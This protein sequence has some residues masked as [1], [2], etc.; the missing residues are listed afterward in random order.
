M[1]K[2]F[3]AVI[4]CLIMLLQPMTVAHAAFDSDESQYNPSPGKYTLQETESDEYLQETEPRAVGNEIN[5]EVQIQLDFPVTEEGVNILKDAFTASLKSED[6]GE[7]TNVNTKTTS[8][9]TI[10]C[11]AENVQPGEYTLI[12]DAEYFFRNYQQKVFV[13][14][15]AKTTVVLSDSYASYRGDGKTSPGVFALGDLNGDGNIDSTDG[16]ILVEYIGQSKIKTDNAENDEFKAIY[17]LNF[18]GELNIGDIGILVNN[19]DEEKREATP[20]VTVLSS[21]V[22]I[23]TVNSFVDESSERTLDTIMEDHEKMIVLAPENK[24]E[25]ISQENPIE[26]KMDVAST[27]PVDGI[28]ISAPAETGPKSGTIEVEV[29]DEDNPDSA[30][31]IITVP[32]VDADSEQPAPAPAR[33]KMRMFR[34]APIAKATAVRQADGSIVIDLGRQVAIKKVT[35]VVT[36]TASSANLTEIAKVEFLND[37]ES[38]IPEPELNIPQNITI[39]GIGDSFTVS[40]DPETNVA[41]YQ[42]AVSAK[43]KNGKVYEEQFYS[44][45][46][47]RILIQSFKGGVKDKVTPLWTYSVRVKSVNGSWSSAYSETVTHFQYP[48]GAPDAPDNLKLNG[49]YRQIDASWKDMPGTEK[50]TLEYREVGTEEY[51]VINDIV[52]NSFSITENLKDDTSYEVRVYGWNTD[53][54]GNARR[55]GYSLPAIAKTT[56]D[57]PKFSKY[58]MIPREEIASVSCFAYQ[59]PGGPGGFDMTQYTDDNPFRHEN[60]IDGDYTTFLHTNKGYPHGA[61]VEFKTVQTI[62]EILMTTR[63]EDKYRDSTG[64]SQAELE[65]WDAEG[66]RTVYR[67]GVYALYASNPAAKNTMRFVLP[68]PVNAKKVKLVL[69]KYGAGVI[70]ISEL[71]FFK[72]DSLEKDVNALYADDMHITLKEN[73]TEEMI[74]ALE[75]RANTKDANFNEYHPKKQILEAEL[76]YA[77]DLLNNNSNISNVVNVKYDITRSGTNN[78]GF[79]GGLCGLQPLGYVAAADSTVNI[80]VGQKGKKVGDPVSVRLVVTQYHPESSAWR[81]GE[82]T[83]YH[84][85]NEVTI[86]NISSLGFEKGGSLYIVQTNP[87]DI[88]ANPVS[89]RVSGGTKIPVLD[90]HRSVGDSRFTIDEAQWKDSIREYVKELTSYS[91]ALKEMHADHEAEVGGFEYGNGSNCFLNSTEI[92]LD[93]VLISV[94]ASQVLAGIGGANAPVDTLVERMYNSAV[95]MNQML[96]LFYKERGFN[97]AAANGLHGIPT[98]RFNIRYHRMFAGAFMY[99]GGLHLGIEWGSVPGVVSGV[100]LTTEENGKRTGGSIFGWG[101]AHELGHNADG[102]GVAIAEVTNNIW[103]QLTKTWDTATTTRVPYQSVYKHVTSNTVGKPSSVFAQLG[104]FWQLH[105]AYD[106]NYTFYNYFK[107]GFTAENHSNLLENEFYARFYTIRR[108]FAKAPATSIKLANG[109]TE[110]NIMRTA[111]AAAQKDL[112][113]FFKAW[114]YSVDAV[115]EAYAKQFPK[116]ERKIQYLSDGAR[117]YT[118]AKGAPMTSTEVDAQLVQGKGNDGRKVTLTISLPNEANM[119]AVLGYEIIRN[120]R[121]VAFV[122]P[123]VN[124]DGEYEAVTVYEDIVQTVNNRVM[125]YEVVAYDKYLNT[126]SAKVLDSI[127]IR[128]EGVLTAENWTVT[129]NAASSEGVLT[130]YDGKDVAEGKNVAEGN[131]YTDAVTGDKV[132][133]NKSMDVKYLEEETGELLRSYSAAV[134]TADGDAEVGFE[135]K[136]ESTAQITYDLGGKQEITGLAFVGGSTQPWKFLL[137]YS[138]NGGASFTRITG[139]SVGTT[140]E[141][142]P[143]LYFAAG[144]N[145]K[146]FKATNIRIS[147]PNGV[148]T[149]GYKEIKLLTP[150]GDN[151]DIGISTIDPVTGAETWNTDN[152]IGL[153]SKDYVLDEAAGSVIPAGSFVVTGRYTGNAAYNVV[154]LY[155]EN[156]KLY[157]ESTENKLGGLVN[158]YQSI[159]ADMPEEGNIVNVRDG[160]W[161]YWLEPLSGENAGKFGLPGAGENGS[162][163]IVEIPAKVYAELYRVDNALTL[164]GERLVSDSFVVDVPE[165]LPSIELVSEN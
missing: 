142:Y 4:L 123:A 56:V 102:G 152:A 52:K 87:N 108:E 140:D 18:D 78:C 19:M 48:A 110:Q 79:S 39:D 74:A 14:E 84:G 153:L 155:N 54:K 150:S 101:I 120:G 131:V 112:T 144:K 148:K 113:D 163:I 69:S 51:I 165:V 104:M 136:A 44:A 138:D 160:F 114:G 93:N 3:L 72:F 130:V 43:D 68:A 126:T 46:V 80:Y 164:A 159:F 127:K 85:K 49:K 6:S 13:E 16:D 35:I 73:V 67:L 115:T 9:H 30:P 32:I 145:I 15:G 125:N 141:G 26:I 157:D 91:Q 70:T 116:E 132:T 117:E 135:G 40:W 122:T 10:I 118:L 149:I 62:S 64:Y 71:N 1:K 76:A 161:I 2:R 27:V 134:L 129:T 89:I 143:V 151:V 22:K 107:D 88:K 58:A 99:A 75:V 50:Y 17:D 139:F 162:D 47:N 33:A 11:T 8:D 61:V 25:E 21:A 81:S 92:G 98:A 103:A 156:Y 36:A 83:L 37:M 65:V 5:F 31:E 128:H 53:V 24:E 38:R 109:N 111:C 20:I 100:P 82:I 55:G 105:L 90:L 42:V 154:K 86:P 121:P 95:A 57:I 23:D 133:Y 97:P 66:N 77:R 106:E 34:A 96:E 63:L 137:E 60:V 41:G 119:D 94:P 28:V 147:S 146:S 7:I 124:E 45:G 29:V 12:L 158:G 59:G